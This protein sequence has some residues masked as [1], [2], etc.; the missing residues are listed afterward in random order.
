MNFDRPVL[1]PF[2]PIQEN[3]SFIQLFQQ[4]PKKQ[5]L[6]PTVSTTFKKL[7][8]AV[9]DKTRNDFCPQEGGS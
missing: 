6:N 8:I 9:K 7:T 1:R 4:H 2:R 3:V 5:H